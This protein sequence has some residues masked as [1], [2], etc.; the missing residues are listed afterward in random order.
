MATTL[1]LYWFIQGFCVWFLSLICIFHVYGSMC[2]KVILVIYRGPEKGI[3][4]G[5]RKTELKHDKGL[6]IRYQ[7]GVVLNHRD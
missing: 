5:D 4:L 6:T 2:A 1:K 7:G 3:R